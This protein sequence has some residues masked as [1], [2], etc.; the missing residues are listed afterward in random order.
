MDSSNG[1]PQGA[2]RNVPLDIIK[3]SQQEGDTLPRGD[4]IPRWT[5]QKK[6]ADNEIRGMVRKPHG[7]G[8]KSRN[9][10]E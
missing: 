9:I 6:A 2:G 10:I 7:G 4:I 8:V 3:L 5:K 1:H